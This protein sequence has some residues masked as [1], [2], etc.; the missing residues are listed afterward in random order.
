MQIVQVEEHVMGTHILHQ[1]VYLN[2]MVDE[3]GMQV[4]QIGMIVHMVMLDDYVE[5]VMMLMDVYQ[6]TLIKTLTGIEEVYCVV[7]VISY[8]ITTQI[9]HIELVQQVHRIIF[10]LNKLLLLKLLH[11]LVLEEVVH[12]IEHVEQVIL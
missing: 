12:Q 8:Q 4:I 2:M 10:L 9:L 5:M 6:M 7:V 3:H 1:I 11:V